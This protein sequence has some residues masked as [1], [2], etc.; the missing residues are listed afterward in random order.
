[1]LNQYHF[2]LLSTPKI[3]LIYEKFVY[4]R[5]LNH[6]FCS[7]SVWW[8]TRHCNWTSIWQSCSPG[9]GCEDDFH[10]E[11]VHPVNIPKIGHLGP[12]EQTEENRGMILPGRDLD[13][14]VLGPWG[15]LLLQQLCQWGVGREWGRAFRM[16]S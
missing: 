2:F 3:P 10:P 16:R 6:N 1:M 15:K 12:A 11:R 4:R 14:I 9:L 5:T 13:N 7:G 8:Q